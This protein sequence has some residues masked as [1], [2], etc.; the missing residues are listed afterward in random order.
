MKVI[1][2]YEQAIQNG[3][4]DLLKEVFAIRV[5]LE[6]PGGESF[7]HPADTASRIMSQVATVLPEIKNILTA[8]AGND[9][10]LLSFESKIE[11]LQL[12]AV[13]Q[14]HLDKDGKIDQLTIYMRPIPAAQ[15]FL[16]VI[17]QRLQPA[18][19]RS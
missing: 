1:E 7:N 12:Q 19:A 3:D 10:Y 18:T 17:G 11:G 16:E 13:D 14:V 8:Y 15:K 4:E 6:V 9:W 5:R 2:N